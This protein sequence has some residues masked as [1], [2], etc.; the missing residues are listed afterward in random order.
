MDGPRAGR[1]FAMA[2]HGLAPLLGEEI[3]ELDGAVVQDQGFDGRS[4]VVLFDLPPAYLEPA[5][6]ARPQHAR[7]QHGQNQNQH[8]RNQHGR[9]GRARPGRPMRLGLAE[10]V[11]VEVG[12]TLRAD[13]DDPRWIAK[14]L[15]GQSRVQRALAAWSALVGGHG[16]DPGYRVVVRVLQERSFLRSDL[17]RELTR[18]IKASHPRWRVQDPA[19]LEIWVSEYRPGRFVA[20]LRV[21]DLRLRQHGGRT[22]ERPGALRPTLAAAMVRQAGSPPGLLLDPCCGSG[23]LLAEGIAAGWTAYGSD[24]D[25]GAVKTAKRNVPKAHIGTGDVRHIDRPDGSVDACVSNLPF[26]QQ[27]EVKGDM[28]DW[29]AAAL[30]EMTRVTRPGGRVVLLAP[31]VPRAAVP[32][33]LRQTRTYRFRLLGTWT[34]LWCYDKKPGPATPDG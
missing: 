1:M 7:P 10:D 22:A 34:R 23:T 14:R 24:I 4:D 20:G 16:H 26:G 32:R 12:R 29:L 5:P 19:P 9:A 28:G 25:T 2:I 31:D 18:M 30:S 8:A 15:W 27:F 21:S 33:G 11:F 3:A 17:R 6:P 13:G